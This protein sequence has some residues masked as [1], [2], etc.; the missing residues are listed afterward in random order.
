VLT[1]TADGCWTEMHAA[2][3]AGLSGDARCAAVTVQP[4]SV[5]RIRTVLLRAYGLSERERQVASLA[6]DGLPAKEIAAAV[7]ISP[8]TAR[9]HLKAIFGKT[10]SQTRQELA[11]GLGG[12]AR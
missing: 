5:S 12:S 11:A 10:R 6:M 4:A 9:D 3:L 8:H 7:Y 2:P 1:R